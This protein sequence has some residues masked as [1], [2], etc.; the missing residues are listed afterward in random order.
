MQA[1]AFALVLLHA[2]SVLGGEP[3]SRVFLSFDVTA[4]GKTGYDSKFGRV[5]VYTFSANLNILVWK[6]TGNGMGRDEIVERV[7]GDGTV[8]RDYTFVSDYE[9][10]A[11]YQITGTVKEHGEYG[12]DQQT[13]LKNVK[14][15]KL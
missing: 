13:V 15:K 12:Y 1:F 10:G 5:T 3:A 2:A 14:Y 4:V 7:C 8:C 9:D 11:S 6:T